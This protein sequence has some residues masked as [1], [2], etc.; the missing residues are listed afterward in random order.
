M[1][2]KLYFDPKRPSG[3][4]T[5]KRVHATARGKT[6]GELRAWLAA[7]DTFTLH[8]PLRKRFPRNPYTVNNI[9]NVWECDL[10]DVQGSVNITMG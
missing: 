10:F 9:I 5:F 1:S 2:G 7:Q 4:S 3:F 8:R 6:A